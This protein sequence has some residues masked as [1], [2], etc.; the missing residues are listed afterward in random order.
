MRAF[1]A[2]VV[3]TATKQLFPGTSASTVLRTATSF[4]ATSVMPASLP[5]KG[6]STTSRAARMARARV[7]RRQPTYPAAATATTFAAM[8]TTR[9]RRRRALA[10]SSASSVCRRRSTAAIVSRRVRSCSGCRPSSTEM[11]RSTSSRPFGGGTGGFGTSLS[12]RT[13][14]RVG[15]LAVETPTIGP[16]PAPA[17]SRMRPS[18]RP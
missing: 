4:D 12:D 17:P 15:K 3:L 11:A 2:P 13:R 1:T 7:K 5:T 18:F 8:S 14:R 16:C 6:A 9:R 10:A